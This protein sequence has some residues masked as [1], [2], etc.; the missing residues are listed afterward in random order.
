MQ[1]ARWLDSRLYQSDIRQEVLLE[2]LR[3]CLSFLIDRRDFTLTALLRARFLLEKALREKIKAYRQAAYERGYQHT[4]FKGGARVETSAV[5][6]FAYDPNNY[7]AHWPYNGRY[8]FD[9]HYYSI[10][11]ELEYEGEEFECAQ[12]IDRCYQVKHWVRNLAQQPYFSFHLPL[13]NGNFYPDF[14]CE[15][16]DGRNLSGGV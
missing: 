4:M 15:L 9:K 8:Q 5:Y 12:A 11:G 10:V 2:W 13:A 1:L 3:R 14:V 7:P 6:T 16:K